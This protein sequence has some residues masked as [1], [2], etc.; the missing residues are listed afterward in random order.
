MMQGISETP[1][2][3]YENV[4]CWTRG[5]NIF[6]KWVIVMPIISSRHFTVAL[7]LDPEGIVHQL[8]DPTMAQQ[9]LQNV[10]FFDPKRPPG[11]SRVQTMHV[12]TLISDYVR[13]EFT[14]KRQH[15]VVS[16]DGLFRLQ[17][18]EPPSTPQQAPEDYFN[19]WLYTLKCIELTGRVVGKARCAK[20][21]M[22]LVKEA[23]TAAWFDPAEVMELRQMLTK[24]I[25]EEAHEWK[26]CEEVTAHGRGNT[27]LCLLRGIS[28]EVTLNGWAVTSTDAAGT[29]A[30][31]APV[32]C[33]PGGT[34]Y[35]EV[36]CIGS[37][38]DL[39][40]G[41]A[42]DD[43]AYFYHQCGPG[44]GDDTASIGASGPKSVHVLSTSTKDK[45]GI[46]KEHAVIGVKCIRESTAD[47][48]V[49]FT[50][51]GAIY[52]KSTLPSLLSAC[53][54]NQMQSLFPAVSWKGEGTIEF[55]LGEEKE[56]FVHKIPVG[57]SPLLL[58]GQ[59]LS[60]LPWHYMTTDHV[61]PGPGTGGYNVQAI[62]WRGAHAFYNRLHVEM[63]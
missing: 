29:V 1:D 39:R 61:V 3:R 17:V 23:M 53:K 24:T 30:V 4:Q 42:T 28:R 19:C 38:E 14:R 9:P 48:A 59:V 51:D 20:D 44:L 12:E 6:S 27:S 43:F 25:Q 63:Y 56:L 50:E 31:L 7:I 60:Y 55:T 22:D 45:D 62:S 10:I 36:R 21:A 11:F 37:A 47:H 41:L 26:Q 2:A 33:K 18:H 8:S 46:W 58:N 13:C 32:A 16:L 5:I 15:E 40:V 57:C 34:V 49:S 54:E 52:F 35:F